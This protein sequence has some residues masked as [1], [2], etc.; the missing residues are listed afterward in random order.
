MNI[1][2]ATHS[3]CPLPSVR[4]QGTLA[5]PTIWV[6]YTIGARNPARSCNVQHVGYSLS[7]SF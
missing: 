2:L 7:V 1:V 3:N 4:Q 5:S 6:T